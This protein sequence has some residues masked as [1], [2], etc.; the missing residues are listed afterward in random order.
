M[1]AQYKSYFL[2]KLE[3]VGCSWNFDCS[4]KIYLVECYC[5]KNYSLGQ[6]DLNRTPKYTS[7]KIKFSIRNFFS[8]WKLR[9]WSHLLKTSL[10]E[11]FIFCAVI[12]IFTSNL[13]KLTHQLKK[14]KKRQEKVWL[15]CYFRA[16]RQTSR[17]LSKICGKLFCE[18]QSVTKSS[19]KS[20]NAYVLQVL[21]TSLKINL[22]REQ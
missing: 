5:P 12:V 7:Q 1:G 22:A 4:V 8:K 18:K 15:M 3:V 16:D 6:K 10:L 19:R 14:P 20:S 13:T 2:A 17:T 9:I 21:N 11:N